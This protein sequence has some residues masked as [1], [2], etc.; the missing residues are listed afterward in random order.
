MVHRGVDPRNI[1]YKRIY[2]KGYTSLLE[3]IRSSTDNK[4][5]INRME[6]FINMSNVKI[7][8]NIIWVTIRWHKKK[9]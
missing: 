7:T 9:R 4:N 8:Y 1:R 3:Y 2:L 5:N 6:R